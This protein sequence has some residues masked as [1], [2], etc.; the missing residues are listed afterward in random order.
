MRCIPQNDRGC[1]LSLADV[2]KEKPLKLVL[3]DDV[4]RGGKPRL[5]ANAY[6][7]YDV[8]PGRPAAKGEARTDLRKLSQWIKLK[9]EVDELKAAETPPAKPRTPRSK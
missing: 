6:N 1:R 8:E 2:S 3:E 9:R 4:E 5:A 7:P